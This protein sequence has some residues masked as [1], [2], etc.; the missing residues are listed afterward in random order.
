MKLSYIIVTHDRRE[1]LLKTLDILYRTTPRSVGAFEVWVVDN[2]SSDG[3][4]Q[5]VREQFPA[6][7]LI[8][9]Q[10]N[11]GVAA[12]SHAFGPA[13]GEYVVLLDDDSYPVGEAVPD[14][15]AYLDAHT[16]CACVV[17]RVVLPDGRAEA[18]AM[19]AVMLSGAVCI[20][21]RVLLEVGPFRPEFFRKA[22]E[23]DLSFRIWQKGYSVER[24]EDVIYRHDKVMAGRSQPFAHRMDL[25]N[26]LILVE[27][28]LP[29]ALRG[30]YRADWTHRYSLLA[31]SAGADCARAA[32]R[33]RVEAAGWRLREMVSGRQTLDEPVV[34]EIFDLRRQQRIVRRWAEKN[35]VFGVVI[36]DFSK[37][38]FATWRACKAAGMEVLAIADG[39]PAFAGQKY[40]GVPIMPLDR[41]VALGNGGYGV[42]G[43]VVSTV[44]PAQVE[45][46]LGEV[47]REFDGP[48]LK[49]WEG[50]VLE[51]K[52]ARLAA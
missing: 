38:L 10:T 21:R 23:Y 2:A 15:I 1:P 42:G 9:R 36:T 28:Y 4:V 8:E 7:K 47:E 50:K 11:E 34:E 48:V 12:R 3:T 35:H 39:N 32:K 30:E 41:A 44:N 27:R 18:C 13:A 22:G 16:G 31:K 40:R 6:V 20:R 14:S 24:F 37:N 51:R 33:A 5:A 46:R 25:R 19:P 26:N 45:M 17:G 29:H 43:V 49:L 52:T